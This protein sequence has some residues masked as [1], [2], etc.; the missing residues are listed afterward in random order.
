MSRRIL[1][2]GVILVLSGSL[3]LRNDFESLVESWLPGDEAGLASGI[4]LGGS[5][6]LSRPAKE[7]FRKVGMLH[8]VAASGYNVTVVAGGVV[9]IVIL[10]V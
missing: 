4:L 5:D 9:G 8:V 3:M 7:A 1:V 2:L 10:L 6:K